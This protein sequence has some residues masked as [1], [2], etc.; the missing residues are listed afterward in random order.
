MKLQ[1]DDCG[2]YHSGPCLEENVIQEREERTET[3]LCRVGGCRNS[4][5]EDGDTCEYCEED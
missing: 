1:C 4:V 2:A 3:A 5:S